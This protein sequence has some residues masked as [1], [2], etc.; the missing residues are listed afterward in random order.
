MTA[1]LGAPLGIFFHFAARLQKRDGIIKRSGSGDCQQ[2]VSG[3][4]GVGMKS[5]LLPAEKRGL[6]LNPYIS[7]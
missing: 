3:L 6:T 2:N 7:I 1:F 4:L 5:G